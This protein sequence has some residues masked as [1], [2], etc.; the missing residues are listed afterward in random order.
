MRQTALVVGVL[1]GLISYASAQD[2]P[3]TVISNLR[4]RTNS[5]GE[6]LTDCR[7]G[8][9]A[10]DTDTD[11]GSIA[12]TQ[13]VSLSAALANVWSGAAWVRLTQGQAL[14]AASI[15]VTL[16]SDQ[17]AL[18]VTG[19]VTAN[20]GTNLNTSALALD[21]TVTG[22]LPAGA[23]PTDTET[24]TNTNLSRIGA[25]QFIYNSGGNTW[26]RTHFADIN[27]SFAGG[28]NIAAAGILGAYDTAPSVPNDES[29]AVVRI[30]QTRSLFST[31]RDAA[32]NERGVNVTAGNALTVDGSATTQPISGTVT[33]SLDAKTYNAPTAVSVDGA[34]EQVL[35]SNA[36]R[37]G[38]IATNTSSDT[39]SCA[40]AAT[41]VANSGIVLPPYAVWMMLRESLATGAINCISSGSASNLAVQELQ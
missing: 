39:I 35:A 12:G 4:G 7:T 29:L 34:S 41:A 30:D 10:A 31:I 2:T 19:T 38:V 37:T 18:T 21:A 8:C 16:A 9:S 36:N 13:A 14:M 11:D 15:P 24:N 6:L 25:F 22:R 1:L 17:S 3:L 40:V 33:V 28:A 27:G 26:Q 23:A 32:G 5:N 20:A